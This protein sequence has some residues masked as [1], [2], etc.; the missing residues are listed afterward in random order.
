MPLLKVKPPYGDTTSDPDK[1]ISD[2]NKL[3]RK[4]GINNYQWTTL[5]EQGIVEL[6]VMI[7][8]TGAD[9]KLRKI[10]IKVTPPI[11]KA[12]RRTWDTKKGR[13]VVQELPNYAQA[14]RLLYHWLKIKVEAVAFGL[15]EVELMLLAETW[16]QDY[17]RLKKGKLDKFSEKDLEAELLNS[18]I[19]DLC[20]YGSVDDLIRTAQGL[21]FKVELPEMPNLEPKEKIEIKEDMD[22]ALKEALE[23]TG[24][25]IKKK[26]QE[27]RKKK[28]A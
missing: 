19:I 15:K 14:M 2:I 23:E 5:W 12:K 9:G 11:F 10:G 25:G 1:T 13:N 20:E 28:G 22:P 27:K 6:K 4:Y 8:S 16:V 3:L 24:M 21:P 7:E 26:V 17:E 18:V